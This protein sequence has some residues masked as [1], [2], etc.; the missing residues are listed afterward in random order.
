MAQ[1]SGSVPQKATRQLRVVV[2]DIDDHKPVFN[3]TYDSPPLEFSV[4]EELPP[5]SLIGIVTAVDPDDGENADIGY[6]ITCKTS[7]Y[8]L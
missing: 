1:D 5:G 2:S 8:F 6:L 7:M 4:Q 3:R